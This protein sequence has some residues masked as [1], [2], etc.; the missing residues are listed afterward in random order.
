MTEKLDL[1]ALTSAIASLEDGLDVVSDDKWFSHQSAKVQ[2][3]LIAGVI[4]NFELVYEIS[5]KML[6]RQIEAESDSPDEVDAT[7]FRNM[8]RLAGEKGLIADVEAWFKYHH[9]HNITAHTYN[10]DKAKMVYAGTLIFI[11]DARNLLQKL[12]VRNAADA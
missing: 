3:T 10:Q 5:I 7:S 9:M 6:R 4:Q 2:N 8:L 1:S 12:E 11:E